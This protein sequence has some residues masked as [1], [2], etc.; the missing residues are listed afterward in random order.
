M[1]LDNLLS[2]VP[3]IFPVAS[4]VRFF[5][6]KKWS[7]L[8]L[9]A[10]P[11]RWAYLHAGPTKKSRKNSYEKKGERVIRL[12]PGDKASQCIY[13]LIEKKYTYKKI[14]YKEALHVNKLS[15]L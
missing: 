13:F 15:I 8:V 12:T 1:P 7:L 6:S 4:S 10:C 11:K 9:T 14:R 2:D 5:V 3:S